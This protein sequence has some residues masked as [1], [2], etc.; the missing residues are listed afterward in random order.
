VTIPKEDGSLTRHSLGEPAQF[1]RPTT[2]LSSRRALAAVH[3]VA[4]PLAENT[5]FSGANV[6]WD[7]TLAIRRHIWSWGLPVAEAMDTAQRGMGM[8]WDTTKELIIRSAA[9]AKSEGGEIA[10][11]AITDQLPE[12]PATLPQII[13]AYHEQINL[14]ESNG[15]QAVV[16]ASRHLAALAQHPAEYQAAYS[17]IL[18]QVSGKAIVHWMGDMF[19]P[20]LAGYWGAGDLDDASES[21]LSVIADNASKIDGVKLSL[22]DMDREI[23]LRRRLPEGV[24]MYTGDDFDYPTTIKGDGEY[25]SDAFLGAFDLIAPAASSAI[26]A[27]D[28]NDVAEFDR[29][30]EPTVPLSRHVFSTPTFY[31]KTGVVFMAY[32]CGY[33]DHFRMV[34][35]LQAARSIVHLSQQLV[36]ADRAGLLPNPDLAAHRMRLVLELSGISQS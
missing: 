28:K 31:Y 23:E 7:A 14:I 5:P 13:G 21:F 4:D 6:D 8:D 15:G 27:L 19:D 9:E 34:N 11:G 32:L 18:G 16:M 10:C 36:L 24:R 12:G 3:V 17:E 1:E 26:Q 25:H 33:Q 2:L 20:A 30:L 29:I 22:L 35:G